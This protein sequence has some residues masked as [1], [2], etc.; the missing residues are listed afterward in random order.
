MLLHERFTGYIH[1]R[2]PRMTSTFKLGNDGK[3]FKR[4]QLFEFEFVYLLTQNGY[5]LQVTSEYKIHIQHI[6][7]ESS[8]RTL[9]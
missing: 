6:F 4:E 5:K 8:M 9:L 2:L 1:F 3:T 7:K